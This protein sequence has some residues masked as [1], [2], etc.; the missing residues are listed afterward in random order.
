[1][2][3]LL[4]AFAVVLV[5]AGAA[6]AYLTA[7]HQALLKRRMTAPFSKIAGALAL[8]GA[9]AVLLSLMGPATAVF[10]WATGLMLLWS[11]GPVAIG[12]MRHRRSAGQ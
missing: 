5:F 4:A 2:P 9:L 6:V 1:M 12:W 11:I 3:A 7:P 8:F 10:T